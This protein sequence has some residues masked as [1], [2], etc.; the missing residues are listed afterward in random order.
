[1]DDTP[2]L[3]LAFLKP[4]GVIFGGLV[5]V[6][7]SLGVRGFLKRRKRRAHHNARTARSARH[8][9]PSA[10][11]QELAAVEND[12]TRPPPTNP[13]LVQVNEV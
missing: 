5:A 9:S 7:L 1:M 13:R 12:N 2:S 4:I 11:R 10:P 3:D 8:P 6:A